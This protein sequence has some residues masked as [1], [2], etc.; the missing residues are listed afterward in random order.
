MMANIKAG[1]RRCMP[2]NWVPKAPVRGF[3]LDHPPAWSLNHV[4]TIN[5]SFLKWL[6]LL[7]VHHDRDYIDAII[8]G[9]TIEM[10]KLAKIR[11]PNVLFVHADFIPWKTE[12]AFDLIIAWDSIFH[13]PREL[14]EKATV[15]IAAN[16]IRGGF[17]F[18]LQVFMLWSKR[19]NRR[20]S[21]WIWDLWISQ[22][23]R[24]NRKD[25]MQN[26]SDERRL[27]PCRW[28][29]LYLSELNKTQQRCT[30]AI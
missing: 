7:F 28:H 12:E 27:I 15:K 6:H 13:A 2:A 8:P 18:S 17:C 5:R 4:K 23:F 20:Y 1:I 26:H 22:I 30:W 24:Y 3:F 11:H 21:F 10:I 9:M 14:Q 16:W 19:K 29:G 25:E